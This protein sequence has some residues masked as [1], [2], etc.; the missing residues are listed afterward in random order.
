MKSMG[1]GS[2]ALA[3]LGGAAAMALAG[4]CSR[5]RDHKGYTVDQ[6]LVATVQPGIDNRD[7]VAKTLGHASFE[8]E[9][10]GGGSWYYISRDTR[11]LAFSTP[12]P[13]KQEILTVRFA[14]DGNVSS[15]QKTGLETIRN[16]NIYG[17]TTPTLGRHTG[18][19]SELF[20]NI[21]TVGGSGTTGP[22]ADNPNK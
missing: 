3:L 1:A 15:V 14:P 22:T 17:K 18:F 19:F 10:D 4:G 7:S 11:A 6:T 21:G 2:R 16:V 20:G 12:K 5:L 8:S 13:V 9:F